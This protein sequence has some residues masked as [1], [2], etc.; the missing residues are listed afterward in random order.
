MTFAQKLKA[1]RTQAGMTQ[2]Q[3]AEAIYV[4]RAA[5]SKW[6]TGRGYPG[7][8]KIGRAHV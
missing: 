5:I 7:V 8:D 4:T 1:L 2:E 6:E 3:L